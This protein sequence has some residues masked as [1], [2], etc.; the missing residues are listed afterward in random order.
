[1]DGSIRLAGGSTFYE[2]RVEVCKDMIWGTVCDDFW[3]DTDAVVACRQLG[4]ST[5]GNGTMPCKSQLQ[6]SKIEFLSAL[7]NP[8]W[9]ELR[10]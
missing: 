10:S 2:G 6:T 3:T 1:M 8:H 7:I 5:S 9:K 4:I